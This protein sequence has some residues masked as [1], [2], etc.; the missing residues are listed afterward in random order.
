MHGRTH[1]RLGVATGSS[2]LA[3]YENLGRNHSDVLNRTALEAFALDE[4]VGLARGEGSTYEQTLKDI[5]GTHL[6]LGEEAIRSPNAWAGDL[7]QAFTDYES[8]LANGGIDMQIL[9]IGGNGHVAFNEPYT[10]FGSRTRVATLSEDTRR[11]NARFFLAPDDV[12]THCI[13]QGI[14]TILDARSLLLLV[15]GRAKAEALRDAV[16]GPLTWACPA[17]ALQLHPHVVI[18]ADH[19]AAALL[20]PLITRQPVRA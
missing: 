6:G 12:P 2:P 11:A 7:T 20:P 8:L 18:V 1:F 19:H 13:T 5:L 4:Y 3:A 14:G 10:G 17:S 16:M 9:G 15:H